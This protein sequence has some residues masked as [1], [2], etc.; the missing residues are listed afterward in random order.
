MVIKVLGPGCPNCK[1]LEKTAQNVVAEMG[2][3]ATVEKVDDM[4]KILSY[5]VMKT[6]ALVI[7][8]KVAISGRVPSADE[9]KKL[10]EN[11]K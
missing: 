3:D 10:I 11:A 4:L 5:G 9:I 2:I 1:I 6:P 8:E 7:N